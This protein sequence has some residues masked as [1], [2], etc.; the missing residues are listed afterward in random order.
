MRG[1][2]D[3]MIPGL[4]R[5][6]PFP[7][8]AT[9]GSTVA[10]AGLEKPTVPLVVGVCEIDINS[11][12]EVQGLKGCAVRSLHWEG[13][14][15]WAW[16][17]AGKPGGS[18]PEH[19]EGCTSDLE[20]EE[21]DLEKEVADMMLQESSNSNVDVSNTNNKQVGNP[22]VEGENA[23]PFEVVSI[24]QTDMSTQD[25]DTAFRQA[26]LYAMHH[27]R[28]N[29]PQTPRHG[30]EFPIPQS[31][32]ISNLILPFL[33]VYNV[34]DAAT[35]QIKKTSWKTPKKFI[36]S[37]EKESLLKSKDRGAETLIQDVAFEDSAVGAFVPYKLP[38]KRSAGI[39]VLDG[40]DKSAPS[41]G[42]SKD[43]SIGQR[44]SKVTLLKP[45]AKLAPIFESA[46]ASVKSLYL[47][48]EIRPVI[49]SY[50]ETENLISATN[51]RLVNID[52]M[53]A[54]VVFDGQS[55]LDREVVAK[56]AVPRDALIDRIIQSCTPYWAILRNDETREDTKPK[57][58]NPPTIKILLE[59][60]SG[61]K[62]VTKVSGMEAFFINP[63]PL[64]DELQKACASS[65]SVSQLVGSSPKVPVLEIMVQGPQKDNVARA[66]ERRGV[67]KTWIEVLDKTKGKKR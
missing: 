55:S 47:P 10:I 19:I 39:G 46:Q 58:G 12:A 49:T 29:N 65:T 24:P 43:A 7:A 15:I 18:A 60:R 53:I 42:S 31:L 20:G 11:L 45:K 37:L 30:L 67:N 48:A 51:K 32:F 22:C 2:A 52:P 4:S 1:G 57:A 5:G 66:L 56:G 28:S 25:I 35:F 16:N 59:T 41:G 17:Q 34:G 36:K 50:I 14:E 9:K 40:E 61:N 23:T 38:K 64:A 6:P 63:Q 62:T 44:L 21:G 8:G 33:P 3:L 27:H 54:N 13:D 26:F